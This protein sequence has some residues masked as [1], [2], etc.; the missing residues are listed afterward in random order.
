MMMMML[1]DPR[2]SRSTKRIDIQENRDAP[3]Y[4]QDE[5]ADPRI[6][7]FGSPAGE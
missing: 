6:G 5:P 4:I 7:G 3:L 1:V 2:S